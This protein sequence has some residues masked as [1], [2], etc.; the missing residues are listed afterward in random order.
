MSPTGSG[1]VLDVFGWIR[2]LRRR[3]ILFLWGVDLDCSEHDELAGVRA[4][5]AVRIKFTSN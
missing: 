1:V 4:F 5:D 3:R 2:F